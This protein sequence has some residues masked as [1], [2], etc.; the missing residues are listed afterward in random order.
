MPRYFANNKFYDIPDE[1][2]ND[3]LADFP[4]AETVNK[5]RVGD[6]TYKIPKSE[7]GLFLQDMPDA[8]IIRAK[9]KSKGS[10]YLTAEER[11]FKI[12]ETNQK[13]ES[14]RKSLPYSS[15]VA[16]KNLNNQIIHLQNKAEQLETGLDPV[17]RAAFATAQQGGIS[18]KTVGKVIGGYIGLLVGQPFTGAKIG[19][20]L[21][22]DEES[23]V[24]RLGKA[25]GIGAIKLALARSDSKFKKMVN[26]YS[27]GVMA[28]AKSPTE[29]VITGAI[30][31]APMTWAVAINPYVGS[32][33]ILASIYDQNLQDAIDKKGV[34]NTTQLSKKEKVVELGKAVGETAIEVL[35]DVVQ[36]RALRGMIKGLPRKAATGIIAKYLSAQT[37]T[38][39]AVAVGAG[40]SLVEGAEEYVQYWWNYVFDVLT[41]NAEAKPLSELMKESGRAFIGGLVGGALVGGVG[42]SANQYLRSKAWSDVRHNAKSGDKNSVSLTEMRNLV[43]KGEVKVAGEQFREF[44]NDNTT[45]VKKGNKEVR[46]WKK[47]ISESELTAA[48]NLGDIFLQNDQLTTDPKK[49]K[50]IIKTAEPEVSKVE[51]LLLDNSLEDGIKSVES[52]LAQGNKEEALQVIGQIRQE[53]N[54]YLEIAETPDIQ[55]ATAW[56]QQLQALEQQITGKPVE[57]TNVPTAEPLAEETAPVEDVVPEPIAEPIAVPVAEAIIEPEPQAPKEV[58][59]EKPKVKRK[60][61]ATKEA[62][63]EK[64]EEA[65]RPDVSEERVVEPIPEEWKQQAK[66]GVEKDIAETTQKLEALKKR[67]VQGV[68]TKEAITALENRLTILNRSLQSV[69]ETIT[70]TAEPKQETFKPKRVAKTEQQIDDEFVQ[71]ELND[72]QKQIRTEKAKPSPDQNVIRRLQAQAVRIGAQ[73]KAETK[74][75]EAES[76]EMTAVRT[77]YENTPQWMT[78]PNGKATNLNERQWLQVRTPSFKAWFGDWENDPK[79]ASKVVDENGEPMVVYHGTDSDFSVFESRKTEYKRTSAPEGIAHLTDNKKTAKRFGNNVMEL[80]VNIRSPYYYDYE[81]EGFNDPNSKKKWIDTWGEVLANQRKYPLKDRMGIDGFYDGIILKN[82]GDNILSNHY[83]V[84]DNQYKSKD[85][86]W[87]YDFVKEHWDKKMLSFMFDTQIK[88]ATAN[89]GTFDPN[90]ADIRY[91]SLY[92]TLS[93][94]GKSIKQ[95]AKAFIEI[96]PKS[97]LKS[98]EYGKDTATITMIDGNVGTVNLQDGSIEIGKAG[99]ITFTNLLAVADIDRLMNAD[100]K[101]AYHEAF[102]FAWRMFLTESQ[103]TALETEFKSEEGSARAYEQ[104]RHGKSFKGVVQ[105]IFRKL[106]ERIGM[107]RERIGISE[108]AESIFAQIRTGTYSTEV[109]QAVESVSNETKYKEIEDRA[110]SKTKTKDKTGKADKRRIALL[111]AAHKVM[112][113]LYGVSPTKNEAEYRKILKQ[114]MGVTSMKNATDKELLKF[115]GRRDVETVNMFGQGVFLNLVETLSENGGT[116]KDIDTLKKFWVDAYSMLRYVP[117]GKAHTAEKTFSNRA[118]AMIIQLGKGGVKAI[119]H[120]LNGESTYATIIADTR[121]HIVDTTLLMRKLPRN[122]RLKVGGIIQKAT[123][124]R[125]DSNTKLTPAGEKFVRTEIAKV[126]G[127]DGAIVPTE[128]YDDVVATVQSSID[129]YNYFEPYISGAGINKREKYT[130]HYYQQRLIGLQKKNTSLAGEVSIFTKSE[131]ARKTDE[132]FSEEKMESN[133]LDVHNYYIRSMA[134]YVAYKPLANYI[135]SGQIYKDA[136]IVLE[137]QT[138][139]DFANEF[140][141]DIVKPHKLTGAGIEQMKRAKARVMI[142]LLLASKRFMV[143][144]TMQRY[145]VKTFVSK[146][147]F[148]FVLGKSNQWYGTIKNMDN[149]ASLLERFNMLS[150]DALMKHHEETLKQHEELDELDSSLKKFSNKT[151]ALLQTAAEWNPGFLAEIGN[152]NMS[153]TAGVVDYVMQTEQYKGALAEGYSKKEAIEIALRNDKVYKDAYVFG[154][155][156]CAKVNPSMSPVYSAQVFQKDYVRTFTMFLRFVHNLTMNNYKLLTGGKNAILPVQVERAHFSPDKNVRDAANHIQNVNIIIAGLKNKKFLASYQITS[157]L[158][159]KAFKQHVAVLSDG[160]TKLRDTLYNGITEQSTL[161]RKEMIVSQGEWIAANYLLGVLI[162]IVGDWLRDF[163]YDKVPFIKRR[164]RKRTLKSRLYGEALSQIIFAQGMPSTVEPLVQNFE[165]NFVN[166]VGLMDFGLMAMPFLQPLAITSAMYRMVTGDTLIQLL[167]KHTK[168]I[169]KVQKKVNKGL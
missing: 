147:A 73:A 100:N 90:N 123:E 71:A 164:R 116:Q 56:E 40:G 124:M 163:I 12:D 150:A 85:D 80:F 48:A 156:V 64:V 65:V 1:E 3:F 15:E 106:A 22:S 151:D 66:S 159:D 133:V 122:I 88:S 51:P 45:A 83:L 129:M 142:S 158:N 149:V 137:Q 127:D 125:D 141:W 168:A 119:T 99:R 10:S 61:K 50:E 128:L 110:V 154:S 89:I 38:M 81:G 6:K 96:I 166:L 4:N 121:Q 131:M 160:L 161:S 145:N 53:K 70:E 34:D 43:K 72:I 59:S 20:K 27:Q 135:K 130:P 93:R 118:T 117:E 143:L 114:N 115:L 126:K 101:T 82:V 140:Y 62:K 86:H 138:D 42:G 95:V 67:K 19:G 69:N 54:D 91:R 104:W 165:Y 63:T 5:Y 146:E 105:N 75:K 30:M 52:L 31:S 13:I 97:M 155:Y 103:Q 167:D 98:V 102:H 21:G 152:W 113:N 87:N 132:A 169:S 17:E 33:L 120:A 109:K 107:M 60:P 8:Q 2:V 144:N 68:K 76:K 162:G 148:D 108:T 112:R 37:G 11:Q 9:P 58:K 16:R 36:V 74:Y 77:Q 44:V 24:S 79:N 25:L 49:L 14:M 139:T 134:R 32:A 153:F 39:G 7:E 46:V 136:D 26:G 78:A 157:E 92:D 57:P 28:N 55:K 111:G 23:G 29:E 94:S 35:S 47:G 18:K 84:R 41:N